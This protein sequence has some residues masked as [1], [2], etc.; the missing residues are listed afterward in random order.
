MSLDI[1]FQKR[2]S[3]N[4]VE[5]KTSIKVVKEGVNYWLK[6]NDNIVLV[7]ENKCIVCGLTSYGKN[8][9]SEIMDELVVTFQ[10]KFI[11]D[12]EEETLYYESDI[13]VDKLFY[14]TTKEYGYII[15]DNGEIFVKEK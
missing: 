13:D 12:N 3:L 15:D 11:T 14:D 8:N 2:F 9:F 1:T 5:N 4:E 7:M 10:T 6:K